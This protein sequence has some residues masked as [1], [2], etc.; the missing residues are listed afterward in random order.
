MTHVPHELMEDFPGMGDRMHRLKM[1]DVHFARLCDEYHELNR[2]IHR[3][4]TNVEPTDDFHVAVMRKNRM[5]LKDKIAAR[6]GE[7]DAAA[8]AAE[9]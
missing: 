6:M 4:E 9:G 5:L 7:P 3:A 8:A 2:A 1:S